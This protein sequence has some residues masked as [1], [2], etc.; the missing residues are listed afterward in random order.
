MIARLTD[1]GTAAAETA[2]CP[3]HDTPTNRGTFGIAADTDVTGPWTDCTGN[4]ELS[5]QVCGYVDPY[6]VP[7]SALDD[8]YEATL[9]E[10][11]Q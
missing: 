4:D 11:A 5:C 7:R 10:L 1:Q 8:E 6:F 3:E 2:L 9:R